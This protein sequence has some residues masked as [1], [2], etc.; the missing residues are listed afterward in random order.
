MELLK[1]EYMIIEPFTRKPW[2]DLT[3]KQVKELSK[4]K[5]DSY[6]HKT[7]KKFVKSK[8]LDEKKIGNVIIYNIGLNV[9]AQ[10][11]IGFVAEYKA[12]TAKQIPNIQNIINKIKTPYFT[13]VITGSYTKNKQNK[14]SDLDI[15]IICDDKKDP[16]SILAEIQLESELNIPKIHPY[17]FTKSQFYEMLVN[18][19]ENYGKETARNNLIITGGKQYFDILQEAI[20]NGFSG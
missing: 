15:V 4:N 13:L 17:V 9:K 1:K 3:F 11:I 12:M 19:E 8:I 7:L 5:S 10:N 20:K 2:K 18:N 16:Q 6:V 14:K